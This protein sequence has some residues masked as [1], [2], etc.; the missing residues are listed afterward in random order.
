MNKPIYIARD[1]DGE[2]F[3][4]NEKPKLRTPN[5]NMYDISRLG[6]ACKINTDFFQ[7]ITFEGG[8]KELVINDIED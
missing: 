3:L 8:P 2:L 5:A 7:E 6:D 1:K 4:Y